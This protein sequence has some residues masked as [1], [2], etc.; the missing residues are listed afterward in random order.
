MFTF[1]TLKPRT[2]QAHQFTGTE[3]SLQTLYSQIS[4]LND[5]RILISENNLPEI[6]T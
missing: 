4:P 6:E 5:V 2:A 1:F 3:S